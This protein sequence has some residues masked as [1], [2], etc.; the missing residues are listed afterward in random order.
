[1]ELN[2]SSIIILVLLTAVIAQAISI[3]FSQKGFT[4]KTILN[5]LASACVIVGAVGFFGPALS[6]I[7]GLGASQSFE[8]PIGNTDKALEYPDG[9]LVVPHEPSGRVQLYNHSLQ[10][11]RGWQVKAS[12]GPFKLFPAE[13][14][15]FYIFTARSRMKY[16]Y[17]LD[18]NLLSSQKY[19]GPYPKDSVD[20]VSASIPTPIYLQAFTH[21]RTAWFV[22]VIGA[23][24]FI[25]VNA[26]GLKSNR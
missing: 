12:G 14:S 18:G 10:F 6:S 5:F 13:D 7:S 4:W 20:L 3:V 15:T 19:T 17:D 26:R 22:A 24:L 11:I 25:A 8:W 23:L 9:Y 16:H 2:F 21:P 1:M